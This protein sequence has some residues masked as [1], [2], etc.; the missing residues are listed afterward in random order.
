MNSKTAA[1][2]YRNES[3]GNAPPIKIIRMLYQGA[4][5]FLD[6]AQRED[7]ADPQSSFVGFLGRADDIVTELR[8]C[9]AAEHAPE[10][11]ANLERLY[12]FVEEQITAAMNER[13]KEP[14]APARDVLTT[15]LDAW[16]TIEVQAA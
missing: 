9:L 8:C 6:Q 10:L 16:K 5:R 14:L 3:I 15:L 7:P 1:E 4:I 11:C 13:S 12:L 2:A